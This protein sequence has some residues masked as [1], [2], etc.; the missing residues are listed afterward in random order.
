MIIWLLERFLNTVAKSKVLVSFA[1]DMREPHM[2]GLA[3][4][5]EMPPTA[6]SHFRIS[7][8]ASVRLRQKLKSSMYLG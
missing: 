7:F 2:R 1:L 5:L 6:A 3:L 4:P 8:G